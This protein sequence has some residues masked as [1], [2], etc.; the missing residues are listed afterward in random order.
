[1][2]PFLLSLSGLPY[3]TACDDISNMFS[4]HYFRRT[5]INLTSTPFLLGKQITLAA[6]FYKIQVCLFVCKRNAG[7]FIDSYSSDHSGETVTQDR[8][9][10][11]DYLIG[12]LRLW[13]NIHL[14]L[15]D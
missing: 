11:S 13:Y 15:I 6:V 12:F 10:A 8:N 7:V 3:G 1:M 2:L 14:H 9:S 4:L 5:R